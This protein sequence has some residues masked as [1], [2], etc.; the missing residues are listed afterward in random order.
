MADISVEIVELK[1]EMV[2][3]ATGFGENP[4]HQAWQ[5]VTAWMK[6]NGLQ[7]SDKL[8]NFGF[9]NPNPSPGSPNYGYELW[10]TGVENLEPTREIAFKEMAGGTYAVAQC[11]GVENIGNAWRQLV[12]WRQASRYEHGHH[13][14][15]EEL[16]TAPEG[17]PESYLF[18]LYLPIEE[19]G[20]RAASK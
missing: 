17:P 16:L 18:N 10:L 19:A 12:E 3:A 2:A 20:I 6:A 11:Q 1:P 4:E 14:W 8:R 5:K 13:Q 15:L 9:N 7:P